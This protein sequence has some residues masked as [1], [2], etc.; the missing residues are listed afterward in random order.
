MYEKVIAAELR[1]SRTPVREALL[2]LEHEGHLHRRDGAK[3]LHVAKLSAEEAESLYHV[4]GGLESLALRGCGPPQSNTVAALEQICTEWTTSHGEK[5]LVQLE[6]R[7]HRLLI[8][9]SPNRTL[10]TILARTREH[11]S[12]YDLAYLRACGHLTPAALDQKPTLLRA[13]RGASLDVL[14]AEVERT[15][16]ERGQAIAEWLRYT[17][18]ATSRSHD[19]KPGARSRVTL[20]RSSKSDVNAND[21]R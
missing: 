11:I 18:D 1:I 2:V 12:R 8:Q 13:L 15:W 14:V 6:L 21:T 9:A 10:A 20:R 7:W 5:K 3:S 19:G 4:V 16:I 17:S